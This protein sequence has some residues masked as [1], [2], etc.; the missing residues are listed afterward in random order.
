MDSFI[1]VGRQRPA[2]LAYTLEWE[3]CTSRP[4]YL[5]ISQRT[6]ISHIYG[7]RASGSIR[8]QAKGSAGKA[9]GQTTRKG[10]GSDRHL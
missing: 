1:I 9:A 3:L 5:Y 6:V 10:Q 2:G 8:S 4:P 7:Y